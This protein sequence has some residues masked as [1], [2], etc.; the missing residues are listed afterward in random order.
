M[1]FTNKQLQA[2][3][4]AARITNGQYG[5]P[6]G[7][8]GK[9]AELDKTIEKMEVEINRRNRRKLTNAQ[10]TVELNRK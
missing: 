7:M 1:R 3:L 5:V 6:R 4:T 10:V 2:L 9:Q 8:E